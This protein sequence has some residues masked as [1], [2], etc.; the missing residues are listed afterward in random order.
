MRR[1]YCAAKPFSAFLRD[2]E[3]NAALW[4]SIARRADVPRE[5]VERVRNAGGKWHLLVVAEDW[6]GDAVNTLPVLAKLAELAGNIDLRIISRDENPDV[7]DGHLSP[8][9]A[10]AIP[11][12][13][14]LD[15]SFAERGW[16][17]SRPRELQEWVL[18]VGSGMSKEERY[19]AVRRWYTQDRGISAVR[20]IVDLLETTLRKPVAA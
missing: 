15:E 5:W 17:G 9:G 18:S 19:L 11:V 10:R 6:C 12:V 13:M 16:W 14:L 8:T 4:H 2:V 3:V 7:M 20:E 1:R